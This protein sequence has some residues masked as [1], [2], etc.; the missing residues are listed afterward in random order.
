M[1]TG[2][3]SRERTEGSGRGVGGGGFGG[4]RSIRLPHR[5][6]PLHRPD[7]HSMR[8]LLLFVLRNQAICKDAEVRGVRSADWGDLQSRR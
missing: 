7:R 2:Q 1:A 6:A 8:S 3:A 5:A 4:G